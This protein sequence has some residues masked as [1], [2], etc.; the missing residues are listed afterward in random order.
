MHG[1]L[2]MIRASERY[3]LFGF[4]TFRNNS[5]LRLSES[6]HQTHLL[7]GFLKQR[8]KERSLK[9]EKKNEE[10]RYHDVIRCVILIDQV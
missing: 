3:L 10:R 6:L 1:I 5:S 7:S 2:R 4:L 9:V 8:V